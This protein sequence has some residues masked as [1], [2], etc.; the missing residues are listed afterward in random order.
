MPVSRTQAKESLREESLQ[1]ETE[2]MY[3]SLKY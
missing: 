3:S 1:I 2:S